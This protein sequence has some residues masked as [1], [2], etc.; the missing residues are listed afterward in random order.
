[1]RHLTHG[2]ALSPGLPEE[3]F[4][5]AHQ[6]SGAAVLLSHYPPIT[7]PLLPGQLRSG[8]H[9]DFRDDDFN[10]VPRFIKQSRRITGAVGRFPSRWNDAVQH[11]PKL[12]EASREQA[13]EAVEKKILKAE[14]T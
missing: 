1:M 8:V 5:A 14:F 3:Y 7:E 4:D 9:T 12:S 2:V 10:R 6:P 11:G 13:F